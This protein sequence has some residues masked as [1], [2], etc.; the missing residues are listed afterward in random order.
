MT[1]DDRDRLTDA[2][3]D[4]AD[5]YPWLEFG[6]DNVRAYLRRLEDLPIGPLVEAIDIAVFRYDRFPSVAAI[7]TVFAEIVCGDAMTADMAWIEVKREA[8][9]TTDRDLLPRTINGVYTDPPGPVW[10]SD[11]IAAAVASVGW[12]TIVKADRPEIVRQTFVHTYNAIR[13]SARTKAQSGDWRRLGAP[14]AP[15]LGDGGR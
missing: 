12:R 5:A 6:V 2:L 7:R 3:K 15:T 4:A 8:D 9:L 10:S 1:D 14:M 13:D 11:L